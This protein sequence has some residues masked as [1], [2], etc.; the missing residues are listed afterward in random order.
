MYQELCNLYG[1]NTL[2]KISVVLADYDDI[3]NGLADWL[4]EGII[5]WTPDMFFPLRGNT[6]W[7]R[8][9]LTH[10]LTHIIT[11]RKVRGIQMLDMKVSAQMIR[12]GFGFDAGKIV[13]MMKFFPMWFAE[14]LAQIGAYRSRGDCWDSRRDMLLRC[15]MLDGT[16]LTLDQMGVFTH[17]ML[18]NEMVYNQGFS[19]AMHIERQVGSKEVRRVLRKENG[20]AWN[21]M[22]VFEPSI[23][24]EFNGRKIEHFYHEWRDSV[25]QAARKAIPVQPTQP[26]I[27]WQK[28]SIQAQPRNAT[29]TARWGWLS[30]NGDDSHRTDLLIFKQG[31]DKPSRTLKHAETSWDFSTS[32]DAV[33]FIKSYD[34]GDHGSYFKEVFS[35]DLATGRVKQITTNGRIYGVAVSPAGDALAVVRFYSDRFSLERIDLATGMFTVIDKGNAGDPFV[36][37]DYHPQDPSKLAVER[38]VS[39]RAGIYL[40]DLKEKSQTLISSGAAQEESPCWAHDNRIYFSADYDGIFNIYS[41]LPDGGDL[42]RHTSVTG[43][44]FEPRIDDNAQMLYFSEYASSGFRIAKIPLQGTSYTIPARPRCSFL[45]LS[46]YKKGM[47]ASRPY[48]LRMLRPYWESSLAFS[49][50]TNDNDAQPEWHVAAGA[51]RVQNDALNRFFLFS[52][53]DIDVVGMAGHSS[54]RQPYVKSLGYPGMTSSMSDRFK[55]FVEYVDSSANMPHTKAL[56]MQRRATHRLRRMPPGAMGSSSGDGESPI[57]PVVQIIPAFGVAVNTLAPS[58]QATMMLQTYNVMP[59]ICATQFD[60]AYQTSRSTAA[61]AT[62]V[63]EL[64]IPKLITQSMRDNDSIMREMDDSLKIAP[65][66]AALPLWFAWQDIGYYNE[67]VSHN[68]NDIWM[69]RLQIAPSYMIALVDSG[70]E[71]DMSRAVK[72]ISGDV[73]FFHGFPLTKY[74][75]I[76]VSLSVGLY[77]YDFA[78]NG[79]RFEQFPLEGN[80]DLYVTTGGTA[81]YSFPLIRRIDSGK[82]IFYNALYG[83]IGYWFG[84]TANRGFLVQVQE[85]GNGWPG[86]LKRSL[87]DRSEPA[88]LDVRHIIFISTD[89]STVSDFVFPGGFEL[90]FAYD[91][92]SQGTGFFIYGR[93]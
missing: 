80:S 27:V 63:S 33:Y 65:A 46:P 55:R 37:L 36:V 72:G 52:G 21:P 26:T 22:A 93:F 43:G 82:R 69:A 56:R 44:A 67:D 42:M 30:S 85:S 58:I 91:I 70:T 48:R 14:G 77:Y 81:A 8:N 78:V 9:V 34:P 38:V 64:I 61:G 28:G 84:A 2:K 74:S 68:M 75:G 29:G 4:G 17:D 40:Y 89:I 54:A 3:S 18:N 66:G 92:L 71:Y 19:L 49:S 16:A 79:T 51:V 31:F 59:S 20:S 87:A 47:S 10:E 7:L 86:F 13:P 60:I 23:A 57:Q 53:A 88:G 41:M 39:G 83:R 12:P 5:I 45:K 50:I 32:G 25:M 90:Q 15:A 1:F 73:G 76:P 6:T 11:M 35:C 24:S 62:F